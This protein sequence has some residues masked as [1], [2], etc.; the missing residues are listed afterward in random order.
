MKQFFILCACLLF[1]L[2]AWAQDDYKQWE[3]VNF[4]VKNGQEANFEKA[5]ASHNQKYHASD[6]YKAHV[7][8]VVSGPNSGSYFQAMGSFTFSQMAG[9]PSGEEHDNDWSKNVRQYVESTGEGA[10]WRADKDISYSPA[11]SENWPLSRFRYFTTLPGEGDRF[12]DN[13]KK[14]LEVYKEKEYPVGFYMYWHYGATAGPNV[15]VELN[16]PNWAA[17]DN[18]R[19]VR[20]DF[21][22][23]M[24]QDEWER[25]L[26]EI[27][28]SIDR[29][30]TYDEILMF[31]QDLSSPR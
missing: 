16:Y 25:F 18:N 2:G 7:F 24:D 22:S 13:L 3:C 19:N 8:K 14:L 11:G 31:K 9:R 17:L 20:D 26:E 12:K 30:K 23:V 1:S 4:R 6:P 28:L 29:E 27:E 10:Y 15:I 5:L 21:Q